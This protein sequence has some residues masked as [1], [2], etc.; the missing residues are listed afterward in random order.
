MALPQLPTELWLQILENTTDPAYLWTTL[1]HISPMLDSYIEKIFLSTYL[2]K[3]SAFALLPRR[4]PTTNALRY[5]KFAPEITMQ[6]SSVSPD[7]SRLNLATPK[8]T[9]TGVSIEELNETGV[10]SQQRMEEAVMWVSIECS[11]AQAVPIEGTKNM[12]WNEAEKV[13]VWEAEWRDLVTEYFEIKR[14]KKEEI[15][16][17]KK[18]SVW[19][20]G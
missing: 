5:Q 1:R 20:R 19:K 11:R 4:D 10:L 8:V 9:R 15:E 12:T 16:K 13:W 18:A 7:G 14:V 17:R 6:Y 2:P 3:V